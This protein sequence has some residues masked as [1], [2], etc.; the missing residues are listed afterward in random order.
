MKIPILVALFVAVV[1]LSTAEVFG[2]GGPKSREEAQALA[3]SLKYQQGQIVLHNGLA[4][5]NVPEGFRYLNGADANKVVVQLWGNPPQEEPLGLL[6]P[7]TGPL[8]R[9][10]W[11]VIISYN[12]DGYVKDH[13]AEKINYNDLLKQMQKGIHE[14]NPERSKQG[15]PTMELVG[16]AAPPRY[17]PETHKLYWAKELK[18]ADAAEDTLNY[19]IRVLGRRGVLVLNAVASMSELPQIEKSTPQILSAI[20]FN[21]GNRY[22]D[23]NAAS[24]DKVATYGLAALVAG[25]VAA[26]LGLF[27]GLWVLILGAKKFLI[28]AA[29]AIA[30]WFRKL[31]G[32]KKDAT[33]ASGQQPS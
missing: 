20:D 14:Q 24:G 21:P 12:E 28:I 13:D 3:A 27:K 22:A 29:L 9:E 31:F 7:E 32:R 18:F 4:T 11:A 30:A 2:Q 33:E 26:K 25:G 19:N 17:D 15:Y 8:G 5:L 10:A 23:F 1:C 6:L 16:W